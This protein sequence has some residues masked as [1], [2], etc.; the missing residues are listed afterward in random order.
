MNVFIKKRV[1][2]VKKQL[3]YCQIFFV[4]NATIMGYNVSN[5]EFVKT[6]QVLP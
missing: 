5:N 2:N 1:G 3:T 4:D 6:K